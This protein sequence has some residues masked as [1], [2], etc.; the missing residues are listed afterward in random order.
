M[1]ADH[2]RMHNGRRTLDERRDADIMELGGDGGKQCP[3]SHSVPRVIYWSDICESQ[4]RVGNQPFRCSAASLARLAAASA[5]LAG[6]LWSAKPCQQLV[7]GLEEHFQI[8]SPSINEIL[9]AEKPDM[10]EHARVTP[11]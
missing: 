10:V 5:G 7:N 1:A 9:S 3:V 6:L 8:R 11:L 4:R 2:E